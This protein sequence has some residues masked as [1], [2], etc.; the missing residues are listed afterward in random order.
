VE[1][2]VLKSKSGKK[3]TLHLA[4]CAVFF[5]YFTPC[6]TTPHPASPSQ[7]KSKGTPCLEEA[8]ALDPR[9]VVVVALGDADE[10]VRTIVSSASPLFVRPPHLI[11][12]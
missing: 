1:G 10:E 2:E 5:F 8:K 4:D 7:G 6:P 3:I 9:P 11:L 12:P